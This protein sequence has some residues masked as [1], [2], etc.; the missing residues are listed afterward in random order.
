M[1]ATFVDLRLRLALTT[2]VVLDLV[3]VRADRTR[4]C[5]GTAARRTWGS[6]LL[7]ILVTLTL[8]ARPTTVSV[9]HERDWTGR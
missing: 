8:R 1:S 7:A 2:V 5:H 9:G 4:V 6:T 3:G